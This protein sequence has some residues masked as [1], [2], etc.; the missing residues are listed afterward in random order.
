MDT[1]GDEQNKSR[2]DSEHLSLI[3]TYVSA[4]FRPH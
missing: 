1:S 3:D 2:L 4:L